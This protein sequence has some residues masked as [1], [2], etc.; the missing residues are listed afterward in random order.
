MRNRPTV[1][2]ARSLWLL[3]VM[4]GVALGGCPAPVDDAPEASAAAVSVVDGVPFDS[5]FATTDSVL[6]EEPPG[7]VNVR[8]AATIDPGGGYI[9]ADTREDQVRVYSRTGAL[10]AAYGPGTGRL[11]SLSFLVRAIRLA[12]GSVLAASLG[13]PLTVIPGPGADRSRTVQTPLFRLRDVLALDGRLVLLVGL[14]SAPTTAL[15][16]VWDTGTNAILRSFFAP[17]KRFAEGVIGTF[18]TVAVARR[19]GRLAAA[20]TFTDTLVFFDTAGTERSRLRIPI[21]PFVAPGD[22]LPQVTSP[23]ERQAWVNQ[24]TTIQDLFW[25]ADDQLLVQWAKGTAHGLQ[26]GI[27]SMDTV[28]NRH[29]GIA[30]APRLLGV[31]DGTF[32]FERPGGEAPNRW[33]LARQR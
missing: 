3:V 20:Y 27:I 8:T 4:A 2:S 26:W 33:M 23:A 22:T 15:L 14:D 29:W 28:G 17:P 16:H 12:D 11:D 5:V 6:L 7:V 25:I 10:E 19:G 21:D 18:P 32:V 31:R 9:I 30:P 24:F 1:R 13:G